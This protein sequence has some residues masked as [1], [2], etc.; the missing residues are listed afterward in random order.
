MRSGCTAVLLG[1]ALTAAVLT[2]QSVREGTAPHATHEASREVLLAVTHVRIPSTVFRATR[3]VSVWLPDVETSAA[4]RYPVLVFPDA[5][6]KGQFRSALANIQFLIDR[7]LIPPLVVV[8]VPYFADR[9]HEL[10][11]QASGSTLQTFPTAGGADETMRFITD[12]LLPWVDSHYPTLPTRLLAGHSAGG[13]F[14]LYTMVTRPGFFRIVIAMSP[15]LYW[16]DGALGA[17]L[18]TQIAADTVNTRTLFLTSGGL[19]SVIDE[20]TTAFG[21]RLTKLLDSLHTTR[22]RFDRRRYPLDSH[23]MTPMQGLV[24]GLR[25][26]FD[27]IL[28]PVDSVVAELSARHAQDATEI[29]AAVDTLESRYAAAARSLGVPAPFPESPLDA[30]GSY[31]LQAKQAALAVKLLRENRDRYPHSSNT[32]ESLG[33][34]LA[35]VGDTTRAVEE[36]RSA[37]TLAQAELSKTRSVIT[38]AQDRAVTAAARAQLH[39]L[40]RDDGRTA[41]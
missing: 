8:G 13:V 29:Q 35:A 28:V 24:D 23:E 34:A 11:P 19:E 37:I 36:L 7:H 33:E 4:A 32:H 15:A 21:T 18:A 31:S 27:P 26:A 6:E 25:M 2:G 3:D 20:P 9:I 22:L 40:H 1:H 16:N 14:A 41:G 12:E 17:E 39:A 5:E 38:R 10:T 30:L